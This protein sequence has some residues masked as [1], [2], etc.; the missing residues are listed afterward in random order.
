MHEGER[1][2]ANRG[3]AFR[4]A[5]AAA[6]LL[7]LA[8]GC[9]KGTAGNT[10][11]SSVAPPSSGLTTTS[12]PQTPSPGVNATTITV[13]NVATTGGIVPGLFLGAQVGVQAYFDYV[14]STGGINHRRLVVDDGDDQ[15]QCSLNDTATKALIPKVVAFVGS[16]SIWDACGGKLIPHTIANISDSL[17]PVV[18]KLPNTFSPQPIQNGWGTGPLLWL[19]QHYPSAIGAVGALVGN[20]STVQDSWKAEEYVL[21]HEGFHVV[22]VEQYDI[23]QTQFDA[24][25]IRMKDDGVKIV[26]LDQADVNG[27]AA[28][29]DAADLEQFHPD[30]FFNSGSAYDGSFIKTA[31]A[32]ASDIVVNLHEALYLGQDANAVPAVQLFDHWVNVA[33]A[34]YTP[35]IYSV[36]GWA[37]AALF[38]QALRNAGSDPTR[39]SVL[40]ALR[41][42][43]TFSAGGLIAPDDPATKSPPNCFLIARVVNGQWQRETPASGFT[44]SGTYVYDPALP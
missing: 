31:G 22:D 44:C 21:D 38:V 23:G 5:F 15:L 43:H 25:V 13:G 17:D 32:A 39:A 10:T 30:V 11:T 1:A 41:Q 2:V 26:L 28:F 34:G 35:D 12:G 24:S 7:L 33:H 20:V 16:F 14:N 9:G 37:S 18:T 27:I 4:A 29:L 6:A 40:A 19:K 8:G 36:F 3:R 42:I